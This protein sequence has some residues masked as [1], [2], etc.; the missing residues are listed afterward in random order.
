MTK[1]EVARFVIIFL[2][3][4]IAISAVHASSSL[5]TYDTTANNITLT[6]DHL[7]RVISKN[8][9]TQNITYGYDV[10]FQG[11]IHN[12]TFENTTI[13]YEYD[14]KQRI[15]KEKRIID[16][17]TFE[18]QYLYDS[19]D[20]VVSIQVVGQK[21]D[22]LFNLQGK[23][24]QIPNYIIDSHY[25]AFGSL[26]NRTYANTLLQNFSYNSQNNRLTTITIPNVQNLAYAYDNVGNILTI[27]DQQNNR[28]QT[29][30][31]DSLNRLI[32][33]KVGPDRFTY[34]YNPTGNIMKIVRN[35]N[36]SKKFI[37]NGLAHAPSQVVEGS[38]GVDAY[39][40]QQLNSTNKT[41]TIEFYLVNDQN[42]S[43]SANFTITFGD[44]SSFTNSSIIVDDYLK[45]SVNHTYA[46][47]GQYNINITIVS[48]GSNDGQN[49]A[50]HFGVIAQNLTITARNIT[51]ITFG[52]SI[53]NSM[54]TQ[55]AENVSWNCT[56][57]VL[58]A[59]AVN[60]TGGQSLFTYINY[61]F[62]RPG[63]ELFTCTATSLDGTDSATASVV[64][65][66]LAVENYNI[67]TENISSRVLAFDVKNYFYGLS[68]T[69]NITTEGTSLSTVSNLTTDQ[70][71]MAFVEVNYTTDGS[72]AVNIQAYSQSV[73]TSSI[74]KIDLLG[75]R[76]ENY[77]RVMENSTR[78]VFFFDVRNTWVNGS[79][80]RWNITD[81][82]IANTTI[83]AH[84]ETLMVMIENN[85][86]TQGPK[87][88]LISAAVSTAWDKVWDS[89]TIK[90]IE[91]WQLN[92]LSDSVAELVVKN[93][94]NQ[95]QTFS[96]KFDSGV[97]NMTSNLAVVQNNSLAF[98]Y[99]QFNYSNSGVYRTNAMVNSSMFSDNM[100]G[101]AVN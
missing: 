5:S 15:I 96:W 19:E 101:V 72:K 34:A 33:A 1:K 46:N 70:A 31:Y 35:N 22:Y 85:Y 100:T 74:Q 26:L 30:T 47:G 95:S 29:L 66:S 52:W 24:A 18:K 42:Q 7:N 53:K 91:L 37:Y 45:A 89:F 67:L 68:T 50:S 64:I 60:L 98:V 56:G 49:L 79:T 11:T 93:N 25:N 87:T 57:N 36:E 40:V 55:L 39:H 8:G 82:T 43:V 27:N 80:V 41:R 69:V 6:Y 92:M 4:A 32:T 20:R 73:N 28:P 21:I 10:Q 76:I 71:L 88:P 83:L 38:A 63:T 16:G 48:S 58:A 23:L 84:N 54:T 17:I 90:P 97:E 75:A 9:T 44:G 77:Q 51:N 13:I 3:V 99:I 12:L 61:N 86:T 94:L 59:S 78:K 62:T 2:L 65:P 81:P 14:N